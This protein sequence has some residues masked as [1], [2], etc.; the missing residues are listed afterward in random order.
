MIATE[1]DATAMDAL[2]EKVK[3]METKPSIDEKT[4]SAELVTELVTMVQN[5]TK[6][7][8]LLRATIE[9]TVEKKISSIKEEQEKMNGIIHDL[10]VRCEVQAKALAT[11]SHDNNNNN[12]NKLHLYRAFS[13]GYKAQ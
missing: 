9:Q 4:V 12:N 3:E 8:D 11:L 10:E 2:T 7:M 6:F 13:K 1:M 5:N